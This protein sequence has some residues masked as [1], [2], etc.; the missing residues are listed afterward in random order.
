MHPEK[1]DWD[2]EAGK[3]S[4]LPFASNNPLKRNFLACLK[5]KRQCGRSKKTL[6]FCKVPKQKLE[7]KRSEKFI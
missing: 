3:V 5:G 6:T 7:A 2:Q 4:R 1:R